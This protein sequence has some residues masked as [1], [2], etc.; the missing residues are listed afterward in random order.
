MK[1]MMRLKKRLPSSELSSENCLSGLTIKKITL[2][3]NIRAGFGPGCVHEKTTCTARS[4]G[5][6]EY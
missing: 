4:V 6:L 3:T 5:A 1:K 2:K